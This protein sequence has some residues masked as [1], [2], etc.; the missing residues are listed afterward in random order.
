MGDAAWA[1]R[2]QINHRRAPP[3]AS[4][5]SHKCKRAAM[6]LTFSAALLVRKLRLIQISMLLSRSGFPESRDMM[7]FRR[8]ARFFHQLFVV[9]FDDVAAVLIPGV[10]DL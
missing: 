9:R 6:N 2:P 7:F 10:K 8:P 3:E 4:G 5:D 1:N